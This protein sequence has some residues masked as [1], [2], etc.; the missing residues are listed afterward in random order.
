MNSG[1]G[2]GGYRFEMAGAEKGKKQFGVI[3]GGSFWG[4]VGGPQ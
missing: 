2:G 3:S 4:G 1:A